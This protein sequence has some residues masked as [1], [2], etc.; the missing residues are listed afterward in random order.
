MNNFNKISALFL[1]IGFCSVNSLCTDNFNL[2]DNNSNSTCKLCTDIVNIIDY[3]IN[4]SNSSINI[5]EDVVR[6]ICHLILIPP[7]KKECFFILSKIQNIVNWI[8]DGLSPG[9]I[10]KKLGFC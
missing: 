5:I 10:C 8:L 7:Q 6:G 4:V 2:L 1:I 3:R 9:D